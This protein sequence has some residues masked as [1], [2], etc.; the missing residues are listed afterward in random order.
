VRIAFDTRI[1]ALLGSDARAAGGPACRVSPADAL[2][3]ELLHARA[4]LLD[5]SRFLAQG[6]LSGALYSHAHET[7]VIGEENILYRQ[8]T[9]R[10]GI[11][12][13]QRASHAGRLV[14]AS[15]SVCVR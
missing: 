2:L 14:Q 12:R 1:G 5:P 10:D 3:H 9:G 4:M 13:P 7:A 11:E 15:C 6:G 8:M